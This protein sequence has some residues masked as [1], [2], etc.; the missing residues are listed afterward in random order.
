MDYQ[1]NISSAKVS[2][3]NIMT[4]SRNIQPLVDA[5]IPLEQTQSAPTLKSKLKAPTNFRQFQQRKKLE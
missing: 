1:T 5:K 4:P 2:E 3:P